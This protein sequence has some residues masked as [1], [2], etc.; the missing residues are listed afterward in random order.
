MYWANFLHIYQPPVQSREILLRVTNDSYRKI[1][2]GLLHNP[3]AKLTLNIN[4]CLTEML[5]ENGCEDVIKH[6]RTLL[7]RG[8][9]ELTAS[10]KYH[11][12]LP[13]LPEEQIIRQVKL[14]EETNRKYF[15][16]AY[17][18]KG[19]FP[20]EMGYDHHVGNT[21]QKL[22][23][24]WM[25]LDELACPVPLNPQKIFENANGMKY[26]FRERDASFKIL[27]AQLGTAESVIREFESRL[28][29][30]EYMLTA[31]DGE[32]FGHH[33]LGLEQL[34][35]EIYQAPQ[36]PTV[37]ISELVT[38]FPETTRVEPIPST[39]ALMPKEMLKKIPFSRWDDPSNP[40][41]QKQWQ[42]TNLALKLAKEES[43]A[44]KSR[45]DQS[46][47]SDQYWW[48]SAK[49]WWSLEMI[50]R[51]A[52]ELLSAIKRFQHAT[53]K[54]QKKAADLYIQIITTGF[55]WQRT[56]IVAQLSRQEDEEITSRMT[57]DRPKVSQSDYRQMMS[58]VEKQMLA[59]ADQREY[60]R[61]ELLQKRL[62]QLQS[63]M[64]KSPVN[65]A[66]DIKVNQ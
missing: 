44:E 60:N 36:I 47:Y 46:L 12:F 17:Q 32:T 2:D 29:K 30:R 38:L 21:V 16:P 45:V 13:K 20:P 55:E 5:A 57:K 28:E 37:H 49:P 24:E 22:G 27:S 63:E 11:P 50:E 56:G 66:E 6:I 62:A 14:N 41:H 15:G 34:L 19:F 35:L 10:A 25:I 31:M 1:L 26:F 61:A 4:A 18:P 3:K 65:Y 23:Y 52:F 58:V 43:S 7:E 59:A 39:W 9:L 64:S 54:D 53:Q 51:G 40:I 48:A 8:Q 42:L 33:R